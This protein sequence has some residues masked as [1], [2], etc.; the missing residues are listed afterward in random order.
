[1][2]APPT[3]YARNGISLPPVKWIRDHYRIGGSAAESIR[4]ASSQAIGLYE[5]QALS[6][7]L[8]V[9]AERYRV[10]VIENRPAPKSKRAPRRSRALSR[11]RKGVNVL[12]EWA[13]TNPARYQ[14]KIEVKA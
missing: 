12:R 4:R 2:M 13:T 9:L 11:F 7:D 10:E 3:V 5:M 1:M 14:V 8:E 6:E